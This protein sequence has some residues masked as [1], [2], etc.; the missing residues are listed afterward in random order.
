MKKIFTTEEL[1]I[2][3]DKLP[4]KNKV[5]TLLEAMDVMQQYNGRSKTECINIAMGYYSIGV[6][7]WELLN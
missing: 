6:H 1:E 2:I 5:V 4:N 3:F 7:T